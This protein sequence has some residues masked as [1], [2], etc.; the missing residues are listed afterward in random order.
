MPT[1]RV[2]TRFYAAVLADPV[3]RSS[4]PAA[5]GIHVDHLTAFTVESFRG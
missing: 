5:R 2:E 4:F 1:H 3:L